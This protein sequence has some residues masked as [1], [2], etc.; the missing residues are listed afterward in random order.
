M[1]SAASPTTLAAVTHAARSGG[2]GYGE[3]EGDGADGSVE[4]EISVQSA[5]RAAHHVPAP[6]T[7]AHPTWHPLSYP[8]HGWSQQLVLPAIS[9]RT[10]LCCRSTPSQRAIGT[11]RPFPGCLGGPHRH[12][13]LRIS[14]SRRRAMARWP[15]S[16]S[17]AA[18]LDTVGAARRVGF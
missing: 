7:S 8:I 2:L 15:S 12:A 14:A 13:L 10:A 18:G 1:N 4:K 17:P 3:Q 5:G 11:L 16:L 9:L 6:S